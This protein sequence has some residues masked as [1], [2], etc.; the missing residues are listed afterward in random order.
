M[1]IVFILWNIICCYF[2]VVCMCTFFHNL[3]FILVQDIGICSF[4]FNIA[5]MILFEI[6][7][8]I[9]TGLRGQY[10]FTGFCK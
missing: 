8:L 6:F 1:C 5:R 9:S 10:I 4:F 7:V 2:K 3:S